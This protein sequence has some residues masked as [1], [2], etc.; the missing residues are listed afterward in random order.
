M[1]HIIQY[2]AST[3]RVTAGEGDGKR[4]K[5]G[6]KKNNNIKQDDDFSYSMHAEFGQR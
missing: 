5:P 4:A 3:K 2:S 6:T 1:L